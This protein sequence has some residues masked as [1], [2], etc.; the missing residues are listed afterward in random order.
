[1][2]YVAAL[3]IIALSAG[4]TLLA[5]SKDWSAEVQAVAKRCAIPSENLQFV[6]GTV[7]F[8]A[9]EAMPFE[10][11]KCV[12]DELKTRGVP[13]KQGYLSSGK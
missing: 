6:D 7:R 8:I 1:M 13:M 5:E 4:G 12:F 10:Q 3:A 9:P 2:N 11:V